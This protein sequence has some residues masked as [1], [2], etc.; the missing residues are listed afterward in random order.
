MKTTKARGTS[1]M[2]ISL[3]EAKKYYGEIDLIRK[4]W[5][6]EVKHMTTLQLPPELCF[7]NWLSSATGQ[8]ITHLYCNLD[9]AGALLDALTN[10]KDRGFSSELKTFDGCL[11]IRPVRGYTGRLSTHCYGLAIDL[12]A[13]ENPL[14]GPIAL[15]GGFINCFIDA[16]FKWGGGFARVDAMHFQYAAW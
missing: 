4:F 1:T 8:P 7:S 12:N 11:N 2:L 5:P 9:M 3:D 16:G 14:G 10:L 15:S 6:D 13:K